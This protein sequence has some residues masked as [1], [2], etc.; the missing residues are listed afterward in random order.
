VYRPYAR[1]GY[2][3]EAL[4]AVL[5]YALGPLGLHRVE[6]GIQPDNTPS[7]ALAEKLGFRRF[8]FAERFLYIGDGWKDH[9]LL[10]IDRE[11][12]S[13]HQP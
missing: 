4:G 8:G 3:T 9:V 5:E 11:S 7:L 13:G 2:A 12:G 6:C 1:Q 10:A